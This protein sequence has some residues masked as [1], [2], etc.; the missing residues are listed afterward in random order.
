MT[1]FKIKQY[2]AGRAYDNTCFLLVDISKLEP[3]YIL[4]KDLNNVATAASTQAA[5]TNDEK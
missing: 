1:T 5:Q 4:V 3:L 2:A